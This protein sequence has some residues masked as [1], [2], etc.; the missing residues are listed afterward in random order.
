MEL[1]AT[2]ITWC[3][4]LSVAALTSNPVFHAHTKHIV[5]DA[6]FV[7]DHVLKHNLEVRHV[8]SGDQIVDCLTKKTRVPVLTFAEFAGGCWN[9]I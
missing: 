7:C 3:D 6:H 5:I 4:N 1:S 9:I 2:P 8:P